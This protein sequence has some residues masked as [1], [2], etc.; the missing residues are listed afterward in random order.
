MDVAAGVEELLLR[1][2][3]DPVN[4]HSDLVCSAG[5]VKLGHRDPLQ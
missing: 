3:S 5:C 1:K 2:R 4:Q